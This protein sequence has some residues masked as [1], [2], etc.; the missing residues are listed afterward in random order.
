MEGEAREAYEFQTGLK[1]S[2]SGFFT[3]PKGN[4][5]ASPDFLVLDQPGERGGGE[6]KCLDGV[7]H[8]KYLLID[9]VPLEFKAQIQGQI[10]IAELD[11]L[12]WWLYHPLLPRK[13]LRVY[14]DEEFITDLSF[15]LEKFRDEMSKKITMLQD[16][17][18]WIQTQP[19][20]PA[21][22]TFGIMAG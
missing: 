4:Y 11:W 8:L 2:P 1:T 17:D 6:I 5:G 15:A 3:D 20:V 22:S 9:E 19:P 12:D 13:S 21:P 10:H 7:N 18:L 16:M 14:R